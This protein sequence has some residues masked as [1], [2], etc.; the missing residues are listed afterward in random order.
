M[1]FECEVYYSLIVSLLITTLIITAINRSLK[2]LFHYLWLYSSVLLSKTMLIKPKT[3]LERV[4]SSVWLMSCTVLL[5]AFS[6]LLRDQLLKPE[7]IYW[8]DSWEDLYRREDL[9]I[10]SRIGSHL[11][12]FITTV[13]DSIAINFR[14]RYKVDAEGEEINYRDILMGKVA[15][16]RNLDDLSLYKKVLI[17]RDIREDIDFHI[18]RYGDTPQPLFLFVNSL[19]LNT[20]QRNVFDHV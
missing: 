17:S 16:V 11:D 5:A 4:L 15:L 19:R 12:N 7:P 13:N 6:G 8:V 3:G 1:C 14:S 18:S 10:E 20:T 9:T 2:S